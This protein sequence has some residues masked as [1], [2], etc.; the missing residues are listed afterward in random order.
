MSYIDMTDVLSAW[1]YDPDRIAVRKVLGMDDI[2]KIQLRVELGLLQ[3][4]V[5]GRP[6]GKNPFGC[7]SLLDYHQQ[8]LATHQERNGT[9]L[10]FM[11][12]P[13]E[14]ADLCD[15]VSLYYRRCVAFFVLEEFEN[16]VGDAAHNLAV[17]NLCCKYAMEKKD[18]TRL[19]GFRPYI[20]MMDA[21]ARGCQ[22]LINGEKASALA[23]I[24]R[25]LMHIRAL[26]Q[27]Y[28]SDSKYANLEEVRIL[29][30]FREQVSSQLDDDE[31]T[32]VRRALQD[33]ISQ[34]R[35]EDAAK[36]RDQL[37]QIYSGQRV[38]SQRPLLEEKNGCVNP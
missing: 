11:L 34:E 15:E 21:R 31:L 32:E 13:G 6:D 36:L 3:M 27:D 29:E 7:D 5:E 9:E 19:E 37:Q 33:A 25:G 35:F 28:Q 24:N 10:G 14:C 17:M 30:D 8:R 20:L 12:T 4:E 1:D 2:E 23:H 26:F 16:V 18:Q 22:A 38:L